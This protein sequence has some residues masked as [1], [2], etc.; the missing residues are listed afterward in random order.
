M[1][2]DLYKPF[3]KKALSASP[4]RLQLGAYRVEYMAYSK[5][6]SVAAT[7]PAV[8]LAGDFQHFMS[9]REFVPKLY[10]TRPVIIVSLPS[11]GGNI[12]SADGLS[13]EDM[14]DLLSQ[15]VDALALP[16]IDLISF[17]LTSLLAHAFAV[18]F[19]DKV[20]RLVVSGVMASP[21]RSFLLTLEESISMM[22][23]SFENF[24][25]ALLLCLFNPRFLS[26]DE[27]ERAYQI[28]SPLNTAETPCRR[29]VRQRIK[30]LDDNQKAHYK[31]NI[32]RVLDYLAV[33]KLENTQPRKNTLKNFPQ[34]KALVLAG[35]FDHFVLPFETAEYSARCDNAEF[36]LVKNADHLVQADSMGTVLTAI[37]SF[38]KEKSQAKN[39]GVMV[40]SPD[41]VATQGK[42]SS[43]RMVPVLSHAWLFSDSMRMHQIVSVK[44]INYSGGLME[45]PRLCLEQA[46]QAD[47][48]ELQFS[49]FELKLKIA[50]FER[51]KN[52]VRFLFKHTDI[53][54]AKQ[55]ITMLSNPDYFLPYDSENNLPV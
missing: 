46:T 1:E 29:L 45:L 40:L 17:S 21:R 9:Y 33:N 2:M 34:A 3:S 38:L 10:K 55:L 37:D 31:S 14:A 13:I 25:Q 16:V 43:L 5:N 24:S 23:E 20:N 26:E 41:K 18:Q 51:Q 27:S 30:Q 36:V 11:Y 48:L 39:P 32:K 35:E 4:Q 28:A 8:I 47:D 53:E 52:I 6:A 12:Q 22:E 50:V 44:D 15:F 19:P 42:R 49:G 7:T 54:K